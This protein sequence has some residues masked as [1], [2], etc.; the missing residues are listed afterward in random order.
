ETPCFIRG[1]K[2]E[3]SRLL[4][5]HGLPHDAGELVQ[6]LVPPGPGHIEAVSGGNTVMP[7]GKPC[8]ACLYFEGHG[9]E[10]FSREVRAHAVIGRRHHVPLF[11]G[12]TVRADNFFRF[13]NFPEHAGTPVV[14]P[15][16]GSHTV[17]VGSAH[18]E[19]DPARGGREVFRS[20]PPHH[21]PGVSPYLPD[22]FTWG[23]EK[24]GDDEFPAACIRIKTASCD[25]RF[26]LVAY[27]IHPVEPRVV[28]KSSAL[29]FLS[30]RSS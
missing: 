27:G 25:G 14:L 8:P 20:P 3:I 2:G 9:H 15:L 22:E 12:K 13:R 19:I 29:I 23:I 21:K 10:H 24:A 28:S 18:P 30:T 6:G 4:P 16:R 26:N 7:K 11:I 17:T 1:K 5:V